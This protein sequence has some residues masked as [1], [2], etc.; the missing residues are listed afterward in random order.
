[1]LLV[2]GRVQS[3]GAA[4]G[5]LEEP[6]AAVPAACLPPVHVGTAVLCQGTVRMFCTWQ[7]PLGKSR[8]FLSNSM[9]RIM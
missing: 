4:H 8:A 6:K 2:L 3:S 7:H 9:S 1:M 5:G